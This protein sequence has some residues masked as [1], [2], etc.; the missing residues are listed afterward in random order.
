MKILNFGSC[1]MDYVYGVPH[2][3]KPGE[4]LRA[5]SRDIFPGGKG[6]NQSLAMARSGLSVCHAGA[7]GGDGLFLRDMLAEAGVDVSYLA[8][9]EEIPTGHAIIQVDRAGRNNIIVLGGANDSVTSEDVDRVLADFGKG[10]L[11][12]LQNE[13]PN[14]EYLIRRGAERGMRIFFNPSPFS[15]ELTALDLSKLDTL[16][17]NEVE[18][19]AFSGEKTIDGI[20]AYFGR[21][22]PTLRVIVT[23]GSMG[24]LYFDCDRQLLCPAFRVEAV[25]TTSAGDTFTGYYIAGVVRGVDTEEALKT[26]S[27]AS[28]I[29]VSRP[30][31]SA[32]IPTMDEVKRTLGTL[33]VGQSALHAEMKQKVAACI[34]ERLADVEL[35]DIAALLGYSVSYAT[36]WFKK[37]MGTSFVTYLQEKRLSKAARLLREGN[38]PI[39][40]IVRLCGYENSSFFR[41]KFQARFG[42]APLAYRKSKKGE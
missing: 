20:C 22:Y 36:V 18:A 7:I 14:V 40:E 11:L 9:R 30:G 41:R 39:H 13:I 42:M 28:A 4:T 24:S 35:S 8:L 25:D 27:A 26:A 1:N 38:L 37:N 16:I 6:L 32:S 29:C 10:D 19:E 15:G 34:E 3:V 17:V 31:A 33:K 12:V 23:L 21:T 5:V 2:F